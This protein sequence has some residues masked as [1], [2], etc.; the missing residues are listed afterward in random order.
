MSYSPLECKDYVK[1]LDIII[2]KNL[3]WKV[4]IDLIALKISKTVGMVAKTE[5]LG[6]PCT[7]FNF[8][9]V[10]LYQS[11]IFPYLTYRISSWGQTSQ[12]TLDKLLLLQTPTI[13]L[14]NFSRKCEHPILRYPAFSFSLCRICFLVNVWCSKQLL[15]PVRIQNLLTRFSDIHSYNTRSRTTNKIYV[16]SYC[17]EQLKDSF[18][19]F[20]LRLW[21]ALPE[22]IKTSASS[23]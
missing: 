21:Y 16:M 13:R 8:I 11:L 20:R 23:D 12:S 5:T 19:R 4:H 2:D 9:I 10:K 3:N 15:A 1:F 18:S 22:N 14:I 17:L 6:I 7:P